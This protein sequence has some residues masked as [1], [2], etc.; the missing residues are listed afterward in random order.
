MKKNKYLV[1]ASVCFVFL[2]PLAVSATSVTLQEGLN[3]YTG[4]S[5][6]D[7]NTYSPTANTGSATTLRLGAY[8]D[9]KSVFKF[10]LSSIPSNATIN[11][12]TLGLYV[13][14]SPNNGGGDT[15]SLHRIFTPWTEP[16]VNWNILGADSNYSASA[17]SSPNVGYTPTNVWVSFPLT[18]LVQGWVNGSVSNN[19]VMLLPDNGPQVITVSSENSSTA[20]RPKLDIDYTVPSSTPAPTPTPTPAPTASISAS[21]TSLSYNTGTTISWS[22]TNATSCTVSSGQSGT[23]GSFSTGNLTTTTLYT[24]S[25]SGLGGN[26]T[27][28]L[29][30]TVA[31]APVT[32]TPTPTPVN[33]TCG[34]SNN[35]TVSSIPTTNLCSTGTPSSVSGSGPWSWS[36]SGSNGGSTASCSAQKTAVVTPTPTPT[37]T[38]TV[39]TYYVSPTGSDANTCTSA[40][41]S[42]SPKKT[43]ASAFTCL[44]PGSTLYLLDGIYSDSMTNIPNGSA[45]GGYI[46]IKALNEGNVILTGGLS[47]AHT[48]QY[49][50]FQ[51]LRFQDSLGH[52]IL[53]NHIKF[54]RNEFKGGCASGNCSNTSIGTNDYNDTADI[55]LEDNWFHGLGGRYNVLVYNANRVI[56]RRA[57]IRHDGGWTD[58]KGDPEAGINFYNSSNSSVENSIVIDSDLTY[59]TWQGAFYSVYNSASPNATVN[60]TWYGNMVVNAPSAGGFRLDGNGLVSGTVQDMYIYNTSFGVAMGSGS[61]QININMDRITINKATYGLVQYASSFTSNITNV[62]LTNVANSTDHVTINSTGGG[63]QIGNQIGYSGT[64]YGESGWNM[65]NGQTIWPF[66]N[67]ARIKKEMCT[68]AGI[69]RGFCASSSLSNYVN[70][71]IGGAVTT[72]PTPVT[73]TPTPVNG[74]CGTSNLTTVSSIPTANLC[75]VGTASTV[76]GTGPWNW[77]CSGSN[78]G[79]T[80]ICSAGKTVVTTTTPTPTPTTTTTTTTPTPVTTNTTP[81]TTTTPTPVTT[82]TTGTTGGST[83]GSAT[84]PIV[85]TTTT[86]TPTTTTAPSLITKQLKQGSRDVQVVTLQQFLFKQ[87]Y[88]AIIKTKGYFDMATLTALKAFQCAYLSVCSGTVSSTGYGATGPKTRALINQMNGAK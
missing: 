35:T 13:Q 14:N 10:D 83:G 32:T 72:T 86:P 84:T 39:G 69:T 53:G 45:T 61:A 88:L 30:I 41:S 7:I 50:T 31:S 9:L 23:S 75:S 66:P 22:S 15:V 18:S 73:P 52:A 51:G 49:I 76:S 29:T 87:G 42:L 21:A 8:G 82:T 47:M 85:T 11:S 64:L 3:G 6:A 43:F 16:T 81:T 56:V 24:L 40:Q 67:E 77:T 54:F 25:C 5:D 44:V 37:P 57:V 71:Y 68:D 58:T 33:G 70:G 2:F 78:G 74:T 4:T 17:E 59:H 27:Q 55:L 12:A 79:S 28:T 34:T 65:A 62:V 26:V 46:N 63:A 60:N 1:L 19:G 36:C 38:A 80:A 20:L 48:N